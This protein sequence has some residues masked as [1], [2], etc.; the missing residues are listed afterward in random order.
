MPAAPGEG[1][2][3]AFAAGVRQIVL[4]IAV[5]LQKGKQA[6]RIFLGEQRIQAALV[7]CLRKKLRQMTPRV[8][9]DLPL[10]NRTA[11]V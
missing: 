2:S 4:Q 11:S 10:L 1:V 9:N 8:I 5:R 7:N 6:F 3:R